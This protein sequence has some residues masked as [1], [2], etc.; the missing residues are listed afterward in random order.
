MPVLKKCL[1]VWLARCGLGTFS[2]CSLPQPDARR[3][4][5]LLCYWQCF[6]TEADAQR[7]V[8]RL[9]LLK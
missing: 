5:P 9:T 3:Y 8:S 7:P 6:G 1:W 4:A 2:V